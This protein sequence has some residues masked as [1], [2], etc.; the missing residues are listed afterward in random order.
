[1]VESH[2]M[3]TGYGML[4]DSIQGMKIDQS[5]RIAERDARSELVSQGADVTADNNDALC[6][7]SNNGH[8][9]TVRY[10]VSQGADITAH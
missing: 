1:M 8:L 9:D 10:L 6:L 4:D 5:N 7:A 2:C 3:D